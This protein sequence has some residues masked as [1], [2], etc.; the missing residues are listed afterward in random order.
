MDAII[1]VGY[2]INSKKATKFR[3]WATQILREFTTKGF[4]LD[5]E[6]LKQ[7]KAFESDFD[8]EIK[9]ILKKAQ[10]QE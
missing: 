10:K 2:R 3:I 1:A 9:K 4:V 6:R 8:R 5:D 7:G